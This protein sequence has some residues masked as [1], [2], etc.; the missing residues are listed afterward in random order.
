MSSSS[1]SSGGGSGSPAPPSPPFSPASPSAG[2]LSVTPVQ[3]QL[4][5]ALEAR[6]DLSRAQHFLRLLTQRCFSR[7]VTAPS[8]SLSVAD[9]RCLDLCM[10][11]L[12]LTHAYVT[13]R[14]A[15]A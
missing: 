13:Q 12:T 15:R 6:C 2:R 7:C 11:E 9:R 8:A 3:Q 1:L 10:D 14:L 5:A 4:M